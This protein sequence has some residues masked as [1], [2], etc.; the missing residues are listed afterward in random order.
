MTEALFRDDAY[1][2]SCQATVLAVNERGVLLD[3][4]V[5]YPTGGGQPGDSGVLRRADGSLIHVATTIK[6]EA[7]GEIVHVLADGS[8]RPDVGETLSAEIDWGRRYTFM[9][10]HTALHLVCKVEEA[11]ITGAQIGFDKSR[12]DF[13]AERSALDKD[14]IEARLNALIAAAHPVNASWISDAELDANPQLIKTLTVQPP[15]GSGRVRLIEVAGVDLQPCGGTH[16]RNT[17]E[18]GVLVVQKIKSEGKM[19][20][21]VVITLAS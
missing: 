3:R 1:L 19:N 8:A 12:V 16:V 10:Y 14:S 9:R 11:P 18:I 13:A 20:K 21:R 5:F 4:T 2:T 15:R 17:S 7:P 6:G